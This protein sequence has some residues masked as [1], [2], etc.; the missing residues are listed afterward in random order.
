M[1]I[2]WPQVVTNIIGF[3]LVVWVLKRFAWGPILELLDARR[4]KIRGDFAEAEKALSDAEGL[5]GE[6]AAKLGV[7]ALSYCQPA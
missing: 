2:D 5:K 7:V 1:H 3:L 6:F 4:E